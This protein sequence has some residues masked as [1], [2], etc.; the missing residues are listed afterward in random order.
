[1]TEVRKSKEGRV[2]VVTGAAQGIG[3]AY[4]QRLAKEGAKVVGIDLN[5]AAEQEEKLRD[6]G[7]E[8]ALFIQ[9]DVSDEVAVHNLAKEVLDRFGQCD[10]LI[11]NVGI[12][13]REPFED[14]TLAQWRKVM[15][16]NVESFFLMCQAFAPRMREAGYGRI[17]NM[18]SDTYGLVIDG[19]AHYIASKAAVIGLT[20]ALATDLGPF[21]ITVNA[22][23]PGLTRTPNTEAMYPD[24]AL[25]DLLMQ[26]Q[27]VKRHGFPTD[28]AG[29]MSF[30][31]SDDA[32]YIT[33]QT[34]IVNG[35]MLR[36][37]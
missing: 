35:G 16:V 15:S 4:V 7:A 14:I 1:M 37:V 25:F 31:A 6:V 23:A 2:A 29:A 18:S 13:P 22:I 26:G 34:I 21:G 12:T 17:V 24:G 9:A 11:N 20:R 28:M 36:A 32:A 19:F 3:L 33:G 30:L 10:I 8:D 5:L 27:A